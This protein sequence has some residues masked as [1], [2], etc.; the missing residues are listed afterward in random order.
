MCVAPG[1]GNDDD[2]AP[3]GKDALSEF[4]MIA[5]LFVS[6]SVSIQLTIAHTNM[7]KMERK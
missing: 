6:M 2:V 3:G 5:L 4:P 1:N 7:K